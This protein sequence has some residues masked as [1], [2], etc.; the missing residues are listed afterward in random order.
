[1]IPQKIY[2]CLVSSLGSF[3]KKVNKLGPRTFAC[4]DKEKLL[5]KSRDF[6]VIIPDIGDSSASQ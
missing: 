2:H 1:M 6:F 5:T 4:N 3:N